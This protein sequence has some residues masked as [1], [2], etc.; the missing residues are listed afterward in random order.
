[1]LKKGIFKKSMEWYNI[2]SKYMLIF[3]LHNSV[4]YIGNSVTKQTFNFEY[5]VSFFRI[6]N[7]MG[8]H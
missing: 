5:L 6:R 8:P 1:M 7:A 2:S 4:V 3:K